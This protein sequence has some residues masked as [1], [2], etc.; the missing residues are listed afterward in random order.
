M[1]WEAGIWKKILFIMV[2]ILIV[3]KPKILINVN[4]KNFGYGFY[5]TD[6]RTGKVLGVNKMGKTIVNKYAY[7]MDCNLMI[8]VFENMTEE[9]LQFM[10][11]C[12]R[13]IERGFDIMEDPMAGDQ[14]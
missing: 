8:F 13:G 7:I 14:I 10:V 6:I 3:Q 5:C 12:C 4:Y 2:V 11:D 1:H 9:W